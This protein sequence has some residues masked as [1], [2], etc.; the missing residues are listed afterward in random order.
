MNK[1]RGDRLTQQ[2]HWL[3]GIPQNNLERVG[4][5]GA[6]GKL[7]WFIFI[8]QPVL[9]SKGHLKVLPLEVSLE[10]KRRFVSIA[11]VARDG[12][13]SRSCWRVRVGE[14]FIGVPTPLASDA[15]ADFQGAFKRVTPVRE[16]KAASA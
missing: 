5:S 1:S 8:A 12:G 2:R 7:Q 4:R 6:E 11:F 3:A 14:R 13:I 16:C 15:E 9:S 10:N